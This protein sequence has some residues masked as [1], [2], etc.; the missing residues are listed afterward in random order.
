MPPS[1]KASHVG[2]HL[3]G[4]E[5]RIIHRDISDNNILIEHRGPDGIVIKLSDLGVSKEGEQHNTL[6]GTPS[7]WP[8]EFFGERV[9]RTQQ[10]VEAYTGAVDIWDLGARRRQCEACG[11]PAQ[12]HGQ[13]C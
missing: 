6:V 11:R 4:L 2:A 5:P 8:P 7:F 12:V 13:A 1:T 3:H 10:M 9:P